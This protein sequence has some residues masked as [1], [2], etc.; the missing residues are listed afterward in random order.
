MTKYRDLPVD[1]DTLIFHFSL[2][3]FSLSSSVVRH[4]VHRFEE[5]EEMR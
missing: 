4:L 3:H 5:T 2:F 1:I